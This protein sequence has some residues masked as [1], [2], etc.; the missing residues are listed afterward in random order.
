MR[1]ATSLR[2]LSLGAFTRA[3][4]DGATAL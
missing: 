1:N 2:P 4:A 3:S